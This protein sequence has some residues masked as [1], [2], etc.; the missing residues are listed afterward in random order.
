MEGRIGEDEGCCSRSIRS[1]KRAICFESSAI[2]AIILAF[3]EALTSLKRRSRSDSCSGEKARIASCCCSDGEAVSM[4]S[5]SIVAGC[6]PAFLVPDAMASET[7][8]RKKEDDMPIKRIVN[9]ECVES[10]EG[11]RGLPQ[12]RHWCMSG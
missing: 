1:P 4:S 6:L 10:D 8:V 2:M 3:M 12:C 7:D 11:L 9:V 5:G